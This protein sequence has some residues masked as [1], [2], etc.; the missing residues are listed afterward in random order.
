[1]PRK[2]ENPAADAREKSLQRLA[3]RGVVLLFNAVSKAQQQRRAAEAAGAKPGRAAAASRVGLL[4]ELAAGGAATT[5]LPN[6]RRRD[7]RTAQQ[8]A[9]AGSRQMGAAAAG[10]GWEVL[11]EGFPGLTGGSKMKDWDRSAPEDAAN[12]GDALAGSGDDDDSGGDEAW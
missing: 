12:E 5:V 3:T 4:A 6:G 10:S 9:A 1:M 11:G 8:P 2:G 7:A